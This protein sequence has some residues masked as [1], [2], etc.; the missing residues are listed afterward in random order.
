MSHFLLVTILLASVVS[1]YDDRLPCSMYN[2]CPFTGGEKLVQPEQVVS[3]NGHLKYTLTMDVAEVELEWLK[4]WRRTYNYKV[5]A[6]TIRVKRGDTFD[7]TVVNAMEDGQKEGPMNG[8]R[9]PNTSNIHLHGLHVNPNQP[10]DFVLLE[11]KPGEQYTYNYNFENELSAGSYWYHPHVHGSVHFQV[12]S[13]MAGL[14]IVEDDD[15]YE[16][17]MHLKAVSCPN[18]CEHEIQLLFQPQLIFN[19]FFTIQH[20]IEDNKDYMLDDIQTTAGISLEEYLAEN[21]HI[22]TT[23]GQIWPEVDLLA[24]STK[25]FRMLNAAGKQTLALKIVNKATQLPARYCEV[26]EIAD[27]GVYFEESRHQHFGHTIMSSGRRVEWLVNCMRAG[28]YELRSVPLTNFMS[29]GSV[30]YYEGLLLTINVYGPQYNVIIPK[31]LPNKP[32]YYED[33]T[34]V[35]PEDIGGRFAIELSGDHL[36][37]REMFSGV[38]YRHRAKVGDIE[39]WTITNAGH[40]V[41]HPMH[42]H[43]NAF[44]VISYNKYTGPYTMAESFDR[45]QETVLFSQ[46]H[47]QCSKQYPG[48]SGISYTPP[49]DDADVLKYLGHDERW[50][51]GGEDAAGYVYGNPYRDTIIVPPLSNITVRFRQHK[52]TGPIVTHCHILYHEDVGMMLVTDSVLPGDYSEDDVYPDSDG[53]YPGQCHECDAIYPYHDIDLPDHC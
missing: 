3:R 35:A 49:S 34:K 29:T 9:L 31:S 37:N 26:L 1:A 39:E 36:L 41:S 12:E 13:G 48:F 30:E 22:M 51:K 24:G 18:H 32:W 23:N 33:L 15:K 50:Q 7:F 19:N 42:I 53:I 4:L 25:R 43:V 11:I 20:N 44:Q 46:D 40:T 16:T 27:D 8:Y 2:P 14:F 47:Q 6:P 21:V 45:V 52:F 17:P 5:P 28:T 10:E 38:K